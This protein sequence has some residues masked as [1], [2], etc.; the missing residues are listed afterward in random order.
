VTRIT[1]AK[2]NCAITSQ[3]DGAIRHARQ[4]DIGNKAQCVMT[5]VAI[6]PKKNIHSPAIQKN[7]HDDDCN[8]HQ[9]DSMVAYL[10]WQHKHK[11]LFRKS[12][13]HAQR[14]RTSNHPK[15]GGRT[16]HASPFC[17]RGGLGNQVSPLNRK[18]LQLACNEAK[19]GEG[20]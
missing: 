6:A 20:Q 10:T 3:S 13:A 17:L 11:L 1:K 7:Q 19:L 16:R 2:K 9:H 18:R 8:N 14:R 5:F 15:I 12:T 4:V